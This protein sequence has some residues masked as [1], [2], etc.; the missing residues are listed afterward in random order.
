MTVPDE[1]TLGCG[2]ALLLV[3]LATAL[4]ARGERVR[5]GR[6]LA[7][8]NSGTGAD[9]WFV[10]VAASAVLVLLAA[11]L[12]VHL[13]W[14]HA[15]PPVLAMTGGIGGIV[16]WAGRSMWRRCGASPR[17]SPQAAKDVQP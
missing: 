12:L 9:A 10:Y 7:G 15:S 8:L 1:V 13:G 14:S 2:Y 6:E 5:E 4:P 3:A 17:P 11:V 16:A